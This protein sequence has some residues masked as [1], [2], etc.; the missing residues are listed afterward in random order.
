MSSQDDPN[1]DC[2]RLGALRDRLAGQCPR[3]LALVVDD[4][5]VSRILLLRMLSGEGFTTLEADCGEDALNLFAAERPD[6]VFM[7]A[8]LPRMDGFE[9]TRRLKAMAGDDFVPVIFVSGLHDDDALAACIHA[10]GDDFLI[11]PYTEAALKARILAMER[12]R[13]LQRTFAANNRL[14][15]DILEQELQEQAL[16]ERVFNRAIRNRNVTTELMGLMQ[17]PAAMFSGDLVLTQ[18]LPDGGLRVLVGDFTGRGLA[19]TIGALPVAEAF[20]AMTMKGVEDAE[21]LSELNHKLH[22]L[23][24]AD[25]FMAAC[26]ISIPGS[27]RSLRWWNGGMAGIWLRTQDSVRSLASHALPLGILP[28][29][30][31]VDR[32]RKIGVQPGDSLLM[33]TDGLLGAVGEDGRAFEESALQSVLAGWKHGE[34]IFPALVDA[35]DRHCGSREQSDDIA[36]LEIPLGSHLFAIPEPVHQRLPAGGWSWS[37]E[38][39]D[40]Q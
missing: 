16:A 6:L 37:V 25:R 33:F 40:E 4:N 32:P 19:A 38:L 34:P 1:R 35:L 29:L 12:M 15:A 10:G 36:V 18:H 13:D 3:G 14:P 2:A 26:L 22:A 27:G 30:S 9:T 21:V 23:L 7:D 39:R 8:E 28:Q 17:R 31:D 24:P 5:P 20:H 11:K